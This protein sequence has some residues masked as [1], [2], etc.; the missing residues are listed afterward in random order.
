[1]IQVLDSVGGNIAFSDVLDPALLDPS[2]PIVVITDS[3]ALEEG[4]QTKLILIQEPMQTFTVEFETPAPYT[5]KIDQTTADMY[6]IIINVNQ[7]SDVHYFDVKSMADIPENLVEAGVEFKLFWYIDGVKTDVTDDTDF[8][9]VLVDTD[10]N[11]IFDQMQWMVPQLSN[12]VFEVEGIIPATNAKHLDSNRLF[13]AD[14]FA[15]IPARDGIFTEPIP[16]GDYVRV[17]FEKQLT[18]INDITI[19][20]KSIGIATVQ[21]YEKDSDVLL[22]TF[23]NVSEDKGYKI[24]LTNLLGPPSNQANTVN[25][26][27]DKGSDKGNKGNSNN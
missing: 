10:G 9:V 13:L 8:A 23:E 2:I 16:V 6:H 25:T 20:A 7:D 14:V 27:S 4:G 15:E 11:G 18:N 21:V 1:M 17:T 19:F 22:A 24:F 5:E 26:E 3:M 12:H